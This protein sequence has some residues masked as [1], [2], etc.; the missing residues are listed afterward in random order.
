MNAVILLITILIPF[1]GGALL[2]GAKTR[3]SQKEDLN[4]RENSYKK[5][6]I[7]SETLVI[8]TSLL[9]WYILFHRPEE[10][11]VFFQLTGNLRFMLKLDGLGSIFAGLISF[12]W[13]LANLYA[14]EY[15]EH[16]EKRINTFFGFYTM[17]YGVT[18]GIAFSGNIL[19]LYFFYELLTLVTVYLVMHPMTKKAIRASRMYLY[20]SLGG[21]AFAFLS[22]ICLTVFGDTSNFVL[23]GVLDMEAVSAHPN[24]VLLMFLLAFC[25][26]GV[27]AA[28]FPFHGWLPKASVAPTPVTAL[29]HAVAVVKSGAFAI[30]RVIYYSYGTEFLRGTWVQYVVMIMAMFTVLYGST[31]AVKEIHL[32]RR[33]AYSTISNLSYI[34]LGAVMM[35]PLGMIG[36]VSHLVIHAF[37]KI[38][39]FFS[40]GAVMHKTGRNYVSEIEG[41]GRRMPVVFSCL[42][43]AGVSL[44]GLPPF[45]GFISKWNIA[46]AALHSG[47]PLGIAAMIVLLYAAFMTAFYMGQIII[48]GW[49]PRKEHTLNFSENERDPGWKM[50]L[51]LI[52]FGCMILLTGLCARPLMELI[53]AVA[54]GNF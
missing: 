23:G 4:V 11:I 2:F 16:E 47:N 13:P 20:Y 46:V 35:T 26:F 28:L 42:T 29:L 27:K 30:I 12:L 5:I 3:D 50:K 39:S 9:V 8:I 43:V 49:F 31:M 25:G 22:I 45:G 1:V 14:F 34:L 17:T 15:M 54:Y 7:Y 21:A 40:V 37:M 36:A 24:R 18:L 52:I 41:L 38:C 33:L 19:T 48:R 53:Q 32:K 51:P 44:M 10:G 6:Q